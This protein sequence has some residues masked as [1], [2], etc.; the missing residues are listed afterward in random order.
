[1][2]YD[3]EFHA[4]I[5]TLKHWRHY[6]LP[7]EFVLFLDNSASQYI[8][9][10]L[11]MNHKHAKWL[12]YLQSSMFV[13]KQISCEANKVVDALSWRSLILQERALQVLRFEHLKDLYEIDADFKEAYEAF[14]NPL[15]RDNNS[16]L[17]YNIQEGLLFK[18]GNL[19]IPEWSMR[20]NLIQ[21]NGNGGL[22]GHFGIDK[23]LDQLS[24]FYY[25]PKMRRDVQR[26]VTRCKV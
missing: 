26:F 10:Q 1:M 11:K 17:D 2:S 23:T 16:W 22:V 20:E 14:Q 8:M 3:K 19:C 5:Q 25:W 13:L 24:H 6:L 15:L 18:G 9:Q 12:K 4:V 7:N 21:E